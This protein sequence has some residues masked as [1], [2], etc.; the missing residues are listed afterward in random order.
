MSDEAMEPDGGVVAGELDPPQA[1]A[2]EEP[3]AADAQEATALSDA[4]IESLLAQAAETD[5]QTDDGEGVADDLLDDAAIEAL[6]AEAAEAGDLAGAP[7]GAAAFPFRG[8]TT[9]AV[10]P[11]ASPRNA[12]RVGD[13]DLLADVVLELSAEIGRAELSIDDILKLRAGSVIELDKLAGEPVELYV[14]E[15]CIARGEVVVVD[16]R[17]G[18]RITEL[19]ERS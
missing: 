18:I 17:F 4:A 10:P 13:L 11:G 12:E 6:L 15:K 5:G 2:E 3:A 8:A 1:G 14:N 9:G 7:L 19:G 16:D